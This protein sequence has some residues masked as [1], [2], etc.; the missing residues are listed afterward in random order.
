MRSKVPVAAW[1][2]TIG[3]AIPVV[4]A[5]PGFFGFIGQRPGRIP[6]EPLHPLLGPID[7]SVPLF[8][9]LY[10]TIA[11]G[12]WHLVRSPWHLL[13]ALQA[14]VILQV[15]R[16]L[17]LFTFTLEPPPDIIDLIDPVT[18]LFYPGDLPF[19][20]DLFFSGHTATL[21]LLALSMPTARWRW[22]VWIAAFLVALAVVAQHV[23]WTIDVLAAPVFAALA[24]WSAAGTVRWSTGGRNADASA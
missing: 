12:L 2:V 3:A 14:Y 19:R 16:M 9:L 13:R 4:L 5:L 21:A 17:S 11:V 24:W 23:H 7:I 8:V 22:P 18:Q 15:L 1:V 20:K 6:F 10:A